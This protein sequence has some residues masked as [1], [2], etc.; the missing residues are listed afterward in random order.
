MGANVNILRGIND[1]EKNKI[2]AFSN[3][4]IVTSNI[5]SYPP[6]VLEFLTSDVPVVSTPASGPAYILSKDKSFGKV[7][8]FSSKLLA[9][10]IIS[11]YMEWKKDEELYFSQRKALFY[12]ARKMFNSSN[13][14]D[15]YRHMIV[16]VRAMK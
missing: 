9:E 7:V 15:S 11:Y 3:L 6:V 8:S 10:S 2:I 5:E 1:I 13:M 12:S 4:D 16:Q 14:P